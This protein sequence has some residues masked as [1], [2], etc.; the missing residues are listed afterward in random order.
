MQDL[1]PLLSEDACC[2]LTATA[3]EWQQLCVLEDKIA[4]CL[5]RCKSATDMDTA[6][7]AAEL[8]NRRTWDP[9]AQPGW[10]AF[11]VLQGLEI[12]RRQ[13]TVAQHML[14]HPGG[15]GL[16]EDERGAILQLNMGEG[17]TRVILPMLVLALCGRGE[18]VRMNFLQEL[19]P[20]AVD[21]LHSC[22]TGVPATCSLLRWL[23]VD[24][25][26]RCTR[27]W[28]DNLAIVCAII[29]VAQFLWHIIPSQ[30]SQIQLTWV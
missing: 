24:C 30:P 6:D 7:L 9:H 5:R 10:L 27:L 16:P 19:L 28:A 1:N 8:G 26:C 12:R 18:V 22:L 2:K 29:I 17:K 15:P 3:Q 13:A 11:E 14:K 23:P 21:Y 25:T 4:R 20:E